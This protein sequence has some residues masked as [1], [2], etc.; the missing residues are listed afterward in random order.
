MLKKLCTT[1]ILMLILTIMTTPVLAVSE[2]NIIINGE[3]Q[4]RQAIVCDGV[5]YYYLDTLIHSLSLK[6][7][8]ATSVIP[9]DSLV[10]VK[11][12]C[13]SSQIPV[14]YDP[15]HNTVLINSE[16]YI[17]PMDKYLVGNFKTTG[18]ARGEGGNWTC[19]GTLVTGGHT[20]AVDP[21]VIPL[22]S[23]VYIPQ[24]EYLNGTGLFHAEDTGGDI[25]GNWIDIGFDSSS[26]NGYGDNPRVDVYIVTDP[27]YQFSFSTDTRN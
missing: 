27:L 7:F 24:L 4:S 26:D 8:G 17:F 14:S 12:I 11:A 5:S 18:Y 15:L 19:N 20:I 16:G 9:Q 22:G 6:A 3:P 23:T 10:P 25:K 1:I 13:D 2:S 21:R